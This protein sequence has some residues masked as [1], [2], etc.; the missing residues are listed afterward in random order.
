MRTKIL[1]QRA[2]LALVARLRATGPRPPHPLRARPPTLR[3]LRPQY[4]QQVRG[5]HLP[6]GVQRQ[7][8]RPSRLR[9]VYGLAHPACALQ[10]PGDPP[11]HAQPAV[12]SLQLVVLA[13]ELSLLLFSISA[14]LSAQTRKTRYCSWQHAGAP[15]LYHGD[16]G[17]M[18]NLQP[19]HPGP[20]V[21][22]A[23]LPRPLLRE[24]QPAALPLSVATVA[25]Q[26]AAQV[27]VQQTAHC[28]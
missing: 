9:V 8:P 13:L 5:V 28:A 4:G 22:G 1:A 24:L 14:S 7:P 16:A 15:G 21:H 27:H 11:A 23:I 25:S 20:N 17:A 19:Q 26:F 6:S 10:M 18:M 2:P 12:R 3:L